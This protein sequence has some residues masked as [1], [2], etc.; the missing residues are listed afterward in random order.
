M[1]LMKPLNNEL[2]LESSMP[3]ALIYPLVLLLFTVMFG[4]AAHLQNII[5]MILFVSTI[6]FLIGVIIVRQKRLGTKK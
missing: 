5:L 6:P 1:E 3:K 4:V 2:V